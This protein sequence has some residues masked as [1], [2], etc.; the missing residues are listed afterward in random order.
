MRRGSGSDHKGTVLLRDKVESST[1]A[2]AHLYK[3]AAV[4]KGVTAD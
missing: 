4:D 3:K 2:E 1:D